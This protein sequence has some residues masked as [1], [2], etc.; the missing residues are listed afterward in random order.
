MNSQALISNEI[1][2]NTPIDQDVEVNLIVKLNRL[3]VFIKWS[4]LL[5]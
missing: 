5:K 4:V 3:F 1:N 2:K